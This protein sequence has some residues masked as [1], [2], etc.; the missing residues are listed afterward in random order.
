MY[1]F[2]L[3]CLVGVNILGTYLPDL[4]R[5]HSGYLFWCCFGESGLDE[6]EIQYPE[7]FKECPVTRT[8]SLASHG[9]DSS[10]HAISGDGA[11]EWFVS[12]LSK[13]PLSVRHS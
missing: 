5:Q 6:N 4:I 10:E 3:H 2:I 8:M 1:S 9:S 7:V 12:S 13:S 11:K